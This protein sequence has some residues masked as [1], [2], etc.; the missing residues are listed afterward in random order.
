MN[1]F[2]ALIV[3]FFQH[4]KKSNRYV[5]PL[6]VYT[7]IIAATYTSGQQEPME[8]YVFTCI[9]IYLISSCLAFSFIDSEDEV[10]EQLTIIRIK[11]QNIY[12]LCKI[13]FVW[14][15]VIILSILTVFYPILI[16]AFRRRLSLVYIITM[17]VSHSIIGF[18]GIT[19]SIFFNSRLIKDR[20]M[21]ILY[22]NIVIIISIIQKPL[23][24]HILFLKY[25]NK[26]FP[27]IYL[28]INKVSEI[29]LINIQNLCH[30]TCD[31]L[32]VL[33]YSL[34]LIFIFIKLMKKKMF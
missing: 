4:Y 20:K 28:I 34:T 2:K 26:L 24:Q 13:L 7:I 27:P 32:I 23:L 8:S 16:N 12:Y 22:L 17:I 6:L 30:M 21:A 31:F 9:Y 25:I 19:V 33:A 3:Y 10:Q 18:L 29:N 1:I 14:F 5:V 11:N 15:V